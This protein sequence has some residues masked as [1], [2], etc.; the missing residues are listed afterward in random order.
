MKALIICPDRRPAVAFL[1]RQSP[2]ALVPVLGTPLLFQALATLAERGAKEVHLLTSDRPDQI[3]SAVGQGERWGLKLTVHVEPLELSV[4]E[5]QARF[6]GNQAAEWLAPPHRVVL[7]DRLPSLP[8]VPLFESMAG[9]FAALGQALPQAGPQRL[10]AQERSPGVWLGMRCRIDPTA[11]LIPPCW[12][13]EQVW[14]QPGA[15]IGPEAYVE[16]SALVDHDAEIAQ[17]WVGPWTYVGALTSVCRSLAWGN[18]LFSR[19][20]GVC[21]DVVDAFLLADLRGRPSFARGSPWYGRL[22]AALVAVLTSPL[23][24]VAALR[25]LGGNRPLFLRRQAVL[26]TACGDGMFREF[27]YTELSGF[28]GL[29]RRWPQLWSIVR[30]EFTWVGNRP[31]ARADAQTLQTEFEQLWLAAPVG[32]VSLADT[33][34]CGDR[35]DDDARTHSGF[36]AVQASPSLDRQ[37]LRWLIFRSGPSR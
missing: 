1:A 28:A 16:D 26:P 31:L 21:T 11:R 7:L 27:T 14:V 36:Y 10:G 37:V 17:S 30:G 12:L 15:T 9:F 6:V 32:L 35:C 29:A 4:A 5:A 8:D 33:F 22:A 24:L 3:R 2:L 19:A 20:T 25:N 34:G 23:V 18:R 13:G